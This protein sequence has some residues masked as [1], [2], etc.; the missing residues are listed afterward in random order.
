MRSYSHRSRARPESRLSSIPTAG[1]RIRRSWA[2]LAALLLGFSSNALALDLQASIRA[3][4]G[5]VETNDVSQDQLDQR[6]LFTLSQEVS[7]WLRLFGS[8]RYTGF[9]TAFEV[10][11]DFERTTSQPELGLLYDRPTFSARIQA[12]DRAIRSTIDSQNLDVRS[13]VGDFDW[14]PGWGPLFTLRLQDDTNTADPAVFGRDVSFRRLGFSIREERFR[15]WTAV[16]GFEFTDTSNQL[17]QFELQDTANLLRVT[18]GDR[19]FQDRWALSLDSRI[20][21]IERSS[22]QGLGPGVINQPVPVSQGLYT[23]NTAPASGPLD[24]A[25]G[26]IDGDRESPTVPPI[27][28]GASNTF[29]NIGVDLGLTRPITQLEISVDRPSGPGLVWEVWESPDNLNWFRVPGAQALWDGAFLRYVI[30]LPETQNRFFKAINL[31]PNAAIGVLV[32]EIRALIESGVDEESSGSGTDGWI[33]LRTSFAVTR[34]VEL[35]LFG[36]GRQDLDLALGS[37]SRTRDTLDYGG[38]VRVGLTRE[39]ELRFDYRITDLEE[40]QTPVFE[41]Q[42]EWASALLDWQPLPT[43]NVI[44]SADTRDETQGEEPIRSSDSL[45]LR[46]ITDLFP[47]LSVTNRWILSETDDFFSGFSQ[48]TQ[49]WILTF[50]GRP[51]DGWFLAGG[52]TYQRFDSTGVVTLT[53][54]TNVLLQTT[55]LIVRYLTFNGNWNYG[56]TNLDDTFTQRYSLSWNPGRK[57]AFAVSFSQVDSGDSSL[58]RSTNGTLNYR[59]NR[60]FTMWLSANNSQ[61]FL[62]LLDENETTSYRFGVNLNV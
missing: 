29:R 41:S 12:F 7:P 54:R 49:Q 4:T 42:Q 61:T 20:R 62:G 24:P 46:V 18:F 58:T 15:T 22:K 30:T 3:W 35:T 34:R 32:T 39:L 6:Y 37:S 60:W 43:V 11:P 5:P 16:Y 14:R 1:P 8:Y 59:L 27:D 38:Q 51:T 45:N 50:D 17:S 40:N 9:R 57:L 55:W 13:Y 19:W 48:T 31:S 2:A 10:L 56:I 21:Y 25:P 33:D 47:R 52:V 36:L 23:V 26:L 28:I 44:A 53:D